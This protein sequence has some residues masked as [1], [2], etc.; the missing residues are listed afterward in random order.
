MLDLVSMAGKPYLTFKQSGSPGTSS[1]RNISFRDFH[2]KVSRQW[3][4]FGLLDGIFCHLAIFG[5]AGN[6]ING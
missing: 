2:S 5:I 6:D 1:Q 4:A 3:S